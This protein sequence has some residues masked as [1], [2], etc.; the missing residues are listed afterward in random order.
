MKEVVGVLDAIENV[1][2]AEAHK[3]M[4]ARGDK[5]VPQRIGLWPAML[6]LAPLGNEPAQGL[7]ARVLSQRP[8]DD[9]TP[10]GEII[11]QD[12]RYVTLLYA[13]L[14]AHADY[15]AGDRD[16]IWR[17]HLAGIEVAESARLIEWFCAT[18]PMQA[19]RIERDLKLK[20]R[21]QGW[22]A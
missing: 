15:D 8:D 2:C 1:L 16:I 12:R 14:D 19:R 13:A 10:L 11:F 6:F 5:V 3:V 9:N 18:H 17:W 20:L 22:R 7:L 4:R 21:K